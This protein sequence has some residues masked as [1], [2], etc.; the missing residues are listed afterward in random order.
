MV[1]LYIDLTN[2]FG[3]K[4]A[5]LTELKPFF[6]EYVLNILCTYGKILKKIPKDSNNLK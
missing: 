5:K 6:M 1:T 3:K 2:F 4:E